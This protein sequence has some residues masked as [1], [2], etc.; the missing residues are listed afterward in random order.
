M[1]KKLD[2]ISHAVSL[3]IKAA[4]VAARFSG[5]V[6]NRSLKRLAAKD[7]DA[8]AREI[9]FLERPGL[10]ARNAGF[11]PSETSP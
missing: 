7:C 6:R 8:K 11:D 9:I 10:S 3:I 1:D 4:I 5:R 2:I